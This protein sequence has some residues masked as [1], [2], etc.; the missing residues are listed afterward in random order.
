MH[1]LAPFVLLDIRKKAMGVSIIAKKFVG[2]RLFSMIHVTIKSLFL[3]MAVMMTAKLCQILF[4]KR[5]ILKVFAR[6]I[7]QFK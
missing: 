4:A 2:M 7:K 1:L 3:L 6:T 5:R